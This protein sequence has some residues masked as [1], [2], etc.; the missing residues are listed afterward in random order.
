MY[1]ESAT[2]VGQSSKRDTPIHEPIA[3]WADADEGTQSRRT[4]HK[5]S[6]PARRLLGFAALQA[7]HLP[8]LASLARCLATLY[9]KCGEGAAQNQNRAFFVDDT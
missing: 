6:H 9:E 8:R 3:R 2:D 1:V 7:E 4:G 5:I